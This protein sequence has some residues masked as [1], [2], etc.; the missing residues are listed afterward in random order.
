MQCGALL[1]VVRCS[2]AIL[3]AVLVQFG[4][5]PSHPY[6]LTNFQLKGKIR[7]IKAI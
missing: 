4:E 3:W 5:H 7:K 2:Y 1:L 6:S